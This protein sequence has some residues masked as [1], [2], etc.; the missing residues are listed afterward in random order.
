MKY[1]AKRYQNGKDRVKS[2]MEEKHTYQIVNS[3]SDCVADL[4]RRQ[5]AAG[6]PN[7]YPAR[8]P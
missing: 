1:L 4:L 7:A 3:L 2:L 5:G 6:E 8:K